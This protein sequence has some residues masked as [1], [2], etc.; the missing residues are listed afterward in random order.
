MLTGLLECYRLGTL[1]GGKQ[2]KAGTL[3]VYVSSLQH[4]HKFLQQE[5]QHLRA[6]ITKEEL[7]KI[8]IVLAGCLT[9]LQKRRLMEDEAHT[10]CTG[11]YQDK[12]TEATV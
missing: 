5:P 9:S 11:T 10:Q 7:D 1:S 2:F 3:T 4:F 12:I 8:S 6:V